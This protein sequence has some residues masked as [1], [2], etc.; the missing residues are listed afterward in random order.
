M[1]KYKESLKWT[2]LTDMYGEGSN[3]RDCYGGFQT[4]GT[5]RWPRKSRFII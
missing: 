5:T 1:Q 4:T 3:I 2:I